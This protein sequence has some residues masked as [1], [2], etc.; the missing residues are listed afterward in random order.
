MKKWTK[1]LIVLM[2]AMAMC[3]LLGTLVSAAEN[4]SE[5][6]LDGKE[7]L[8]SKPAKAEEEPDKVG[9]T[10]SLTKIYDNYTYQY[11]RLRISTGFSLLT[12]SGR[13]S[14]KG[15]IR[16]Q[17]LTKNGMVCNPTGKDS[18]WR[19]ANS[20]KNQVVYYG[21]KKGYYYLKVYSSTDNYYLGAREDAKGNR[22]G[23]TR[24]RSYGLSYNSTVT[25]VM[26]CNESWKEADWYSF[27]LS[28]SSRIRIQL[29]TCGVGYL[30]VTLYGPGISSKG[31][32]LYSYAMNFFENTKLFRR[33][34][35]RGE[36]ARP[37]GRYYIKIERSSASYPRT[38]CAYW[39]KWSRY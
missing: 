11:Y 22:A 34:N 19:Y 3:L 5:L 21:V 33:I 31:E 16:V 12:V 17:L 23:S 24:A 4:A 39:L 35:G 9:G 15:S 37:A 18:D 2:T 6:P 29:K 38:S 7:R 8:Y 25:G 28:S 30:N 32:K 13:T 1:K 20:S 14:N 10:L 26:P 27:Y 36:Y